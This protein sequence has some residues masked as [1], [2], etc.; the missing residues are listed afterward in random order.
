MD[1]F[2]GVQVLAKS[3]VGENWD[4]TFQ[5]YGGK[6]DNQNRTLLSGEKA[7]WLNMYGGVASISN[8]WL[9][10]RANYLKMNHASTN[11]SW[12]N[13][14]QDEDSGGVPLQFWGLSTHAQLED[15]FLGAEIILAKWDEPFRADQGQGL[16]DWLAFF[17]TA[18]YQFGQLTPHITYGNSRY[19]TEDN[20]LFGGVGVAPDTDVSSNSWTAGV[21][22]DFHSSA[23][24][25][26]EYLTRNDDSDNNMI[27]T[28]GKV[29]EIDLISA[30]IDVV[31]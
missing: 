11:S 5:L 30:G 22:W 12:N 7:T 17:I 15:A 19:T 31:F 18:G 16:T 27:N 13:K 23:A 25:K 3:P 10:L 28:V 4:A 1:V 20:S 29:Q 26:I 6:A 9:Q 2:E 14:Q 8:D 21:R 24:F